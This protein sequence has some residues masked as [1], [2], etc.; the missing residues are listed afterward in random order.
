MKCRGIL[1]IK[2]YPARGTKYISEMS[3]SVKYHEMNI[4]DMSTKKYLYKMSTF[5]DLYIYLRSPLIDFAL[6]CIWYEIMTIIVNK[7]HLLISSS[8]RFDYFTHRCLL[9][10]VIRQHT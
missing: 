4:L 9:R 8:N 2:G 7:L 5:T 3:T 6:H 1:P 10:I